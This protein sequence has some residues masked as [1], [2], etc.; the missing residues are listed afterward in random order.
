[1][2]INEHLEGKVTSI[3]RTSS[4]RD[5][6]DICRGE[7]GRD[8]P[9]GYGFALAYLKNDA[10]PADFKAMKRQAVLATARA[11]DANKPFLA[12]AADF[13]N[14]VAEANGRGWPWWLIEAAQV[15]L[16]DALGGNK[17]SCAVLAQWG[18]PG[19]DKESA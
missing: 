5:L 3:N 7:T 19:Y 17:G 16:A 6:L 10:G 2:T 13:A 9:D 12:D 1:M 15:V 18:H 14:A 11:L 8:Y 4:T